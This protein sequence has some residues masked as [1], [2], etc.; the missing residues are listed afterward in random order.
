MTDDGF[1]GGSPPEFASDL[2]MDAALLAGFEDPERLGR[3]V[4]PVA[5][6]HIYI[7]SISR[8]VSAWVS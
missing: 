3:V 5:L 7:R 2:S 6:V 8:P 1:D 4:A